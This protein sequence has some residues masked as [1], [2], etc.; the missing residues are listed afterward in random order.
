MEAAKYFKRLKEKAL[1]FS[2]MC[3]WCCDKRLSVVRNS[4][5]KLLIVH[6]AKYVG[7]TFVVNLEM[8]LSGNSIVWVFHHQLVAHLRIFGFGTSVIFFEIY[9]YK[10]FLWRHWKHWNN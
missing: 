4:Y 3:S 1:V 2:N 6:S 7:Q 9:I 10:T 5:E 8:S